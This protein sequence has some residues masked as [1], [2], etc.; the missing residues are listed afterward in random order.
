[1]KPI[2]VLIADDE[3]LARAGLA[4][5]VGAAAD[6]TV[7]GEAATGPQAL[8]QAALLRPDVIL[9]DIQMPGRDGIAVTAA[10]RAEPDPPR[11]VVITTFGLDEYLHRAL[12]AGADG[13]LLKD[14]PAETIQEA[15]RAAHRGE[16]VLSP[17]MTRR[18]IDHYTAGRMPDPVPPAGYAEL[19]GREQQVLGLIAR[20][21]SNA[22]IAA[23]LYIGEATVK[24]HVTRV[25]MKLGLRDRAQAI[26]LAHR[27]GL[28]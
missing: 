28:T 14:A 20:G 16:A 19:T 15:V 17:R 7:V 23:E 5:I 25:L 12:A 6:L 21:R 8:E 9:L 24:T 13:F 4:L 11:I 3:P 1:M 27:H 2:G 26:V 10:L 22:E 18:L